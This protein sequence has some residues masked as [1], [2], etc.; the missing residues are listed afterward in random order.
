MRAI[1]A[2]RFQQGKIEA[3]RWERAFFP[4]HDRQHLED[5]QDSTMARTRKRTTRP[6]LEGLEARQLLSTA[7]APPTAPLPVPAELATKGHP[8]ALTG[9]G[10]GTYSVK[11]EQGSSLVERFRFTGKGT[12]PDMGPFGVNG[13]VTLRENQLQA[14]MA[15]GTLTLTLAGHRGTA[16]AV[17]S[18]VIPHHSGPAGPLPFSYNVQGG[19]GA[20]RGGFDAGTGMLVRTSTTAAGATAKGGFTVD[21]FSNHYTG[22]V[23][24]G[25]SLTDTGNTYAA[26]GGNEP[27]SPPYFNGRFSD[28]PLWVE[29]LAA[30]LGL[31]APT[32]SQ[33][34]GTDY[35]A[36]DA[37][38]TLT[39]DAH[40]GSPNIG[41]QITAY[42]A[43]HPTVDGDQLFVIWGG[44]NDFGPHSTPDPA[45]TVANLSAE[46]TELAK[47][48]AKQFLVP[49]LMPLGETP[50][51]R[52]LGPA[53]MASDD[54]LSSQFNGQLAAAETGLEASLGIKIHPL[55]AY[56]LTEQVLA[57]P[58]TFGFTNV[59]DPAKSGTEGDP[60][61]VVPNPDQ[62]LFW[63]NIHPTETFETLLGNAAIQAASR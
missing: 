21:I 26:T 9:N 17:V 48:G 34:G 52:T 18:Q 10:S 32:P 51:I 42:L 40:N 36:A 35:A 53:A 38:T 49:N 41:T 14:G 45:G 37:R 33:L 2:G 62:Y 1:L 57:S 59:T 25:D 54:S 5:E 12:F 58:S 4:G 16:R 63:D 11:V 19:T 29:H 43:S 23:A 3:L 44:T 31:P 28:G 8:V 56:D 30:G 50:A 39:G 6:S 27:A 13:T 46:I 7:P 15:A 47:A 61:A 22:L 20:F 24:F 55:D 60:G